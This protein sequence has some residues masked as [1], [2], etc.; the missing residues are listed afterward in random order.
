MM[1]REEGEPGVSTAKASCQL[2]EDASGE[3]AIGADPLGTGVALLCGA[4][5]KDQRQRLLA[6]AAA[7]GFI[8]VPA[9]ALLYL[10][11]RWLAS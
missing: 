6:E 4:C 11:G 3:S 2:C 10:L 7:T 5:R 1:L 9:A 8:F